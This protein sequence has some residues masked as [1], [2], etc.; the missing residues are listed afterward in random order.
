MW[1]SLTL[2][3]GKLVK[4]KGPEYWLCCSS[5]YIIWSRK[6][7]PL[8]SWLFVCISNFQKAKNSDLALKTT[9]SVGDVII[10]LNYL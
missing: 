8:S 10:I 3:N 5:R 6:I 1:E 2:E 9:V 4:N 7:L